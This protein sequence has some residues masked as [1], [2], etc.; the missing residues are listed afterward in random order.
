MDGT[1]KCWAASVLVD[2]CGPKN[3][4]LHT[5][6]WLWSV[7]CRLSLRS[8]TGE[9]QCSWGIYGSKK[10]EESNNK[11]PNKFG[12]NSEELC[13]S[14]LTFHEQAWFGGKK[15]W[16]NQTKS[17]RRQLVCFSVSPFYW[18]RCWIIRFQRRRL[19]GVAVTFGV[20]VLHCRKGRN[21][22]NFNLCTKSTCSLLYEIRITRIHA[23]KV[24]MILNFFFYCVMLS[25]KGRRGIFPF[26]AK[27]WQSK[28][29]AAGQK[30]AS[31]VCTGC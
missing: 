11:G 6:R 7:W 20:S 9:V 23:R 24:K 14:R 1:S 29:R 31:H 2:N 18:F 22:S 8:A 30:I 5:S 3:R 13:K 25:Q 10:S 17:P 15:E 19:S 27:F 21:F 4:K 28:W 12:P 16:I 26:N